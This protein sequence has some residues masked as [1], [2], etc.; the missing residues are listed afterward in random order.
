MYIDLL[1]LYLL[2]IGT[3][4]ASAGMTYWEHRSHP[5]HGK[6]LRTL[7]AGF[8]TLAI[9]CTAV[10][11]RRNLPSAIGPALCN[12]VILSGYLLVLSAVA[13]LRGRR[14]RGTSA[15]VLTGMALVWAMAGTRWPE[16][17]WNYVSSFPIAVVSALTIPGRIDSIRVPATV[18]IGLAQFDNDVPALADGLAA[19]DRALYRAKSLGGNRLESALSVEEPA[20]A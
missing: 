18:S 10:L 17:M 20:A 3:L 13:S 11:F 6:A 14:Y 8:A 1:T 2:A 9:G 5:T 19:A 12:L 15:A 16:A 4:L 7:A